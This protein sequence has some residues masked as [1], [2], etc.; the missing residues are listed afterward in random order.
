MGKIKDLNPALVTRYFCGG[1][2][3]HEEYLNLLF[4]AV[5][6]TESNGKPLNFETENFIKKSLF[7]NGAVAFDKITKDW[8]MVEGQ[9]VNEKGNPLRLVM[10]TY[11]LKT[12]FTRLAS[13]DKDEDGAHILYAMPNGRNG[14]TLDGLI[15]EATDFMNACDSAMSQNLEACKTPYIVVCK[16]KDLQL[17]FEHALQQKANGQAVIVVNE[18]LGDGLKAVN[19]GV[20]YLADRYREMANEARDELLNKIGI[21]TANTDKK[22]RIQGAE[23]NATI[24]QATDYIYLVIDTFNKQCDSYGLDYK[25]A[26]NGALEEIY[27]DG[28][29]P[30]GEATDYDVDDAERITNTNE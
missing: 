28:D 1:F 17:S 18:E 3:R 25:M 16:N 5:K 20:E 6:I 14:F 8:Y 15:R 19:I 21:M 7:I 22:E 26:L 2:N 10:F 29:A 13:Y 12:K 30:N 27:L 24:G 23:V 4:N 9:G 11:N